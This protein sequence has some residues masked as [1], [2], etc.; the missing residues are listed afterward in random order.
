MSEDI[1]P[2]QGEPTMLYSI[3]KSSS[4]TRR[5]SWQRAEE[6]GGRFRRSHQDDS[7]RGHQENGLPRT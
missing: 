6:G 4:S 2:T 5:K 1:G 7:E 3:K